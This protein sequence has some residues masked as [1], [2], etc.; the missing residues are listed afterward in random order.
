[1]KYAPKILTGRCRTGSD[2]TGKLV[3]AVPIENEPVVRDDGWIAWD[4]VSAWATALCGRKPSGLSNGW[5]VYA[6]SA[7]VTCPKCLKYLKK[8]GEQQ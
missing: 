8:M 3:H 7:E 2:S 5:S 1:M 4:G 6:S